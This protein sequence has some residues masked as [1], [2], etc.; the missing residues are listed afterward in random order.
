ML[1]TVDLELLAKKPNVC[2]LMLLDKSCD[3]SQIT[4]NKND[5]PKLN[6]LVVDCCVITTITFTSGSAPKLEKLVWSSFTSLS[7]IEN[8][9]KLKELEFNGDI[10][11][12]AVKEAIKRHE[13][14]PYLKCN[15]PAIQ[16]HAKGDKKE[17]DED[18]D[19][20]RFPFCWKKKV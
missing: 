8:L 12:N 17:D 6:L 3:L 10:V 2:C 1:D 5:F 20:A 16:N 15:E 4:F 7:G 9:P 14:Q 18:D 19:D 11:P 13:R